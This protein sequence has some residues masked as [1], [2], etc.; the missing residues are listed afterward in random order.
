MLDLIAVISE[1]DSVTLL[2]LDCGTSWTSDQG[3]SKFL[4]DVLVDRDFFYWLYILVFG[5]LRRMSTQPYF[6]SL[7][8]G[9][10]SEIKSALTCTG[11]L[12]PDSPF[13]WGLLLLSE[14]CLLLKLS[15]SLLVARFTQTFRYSSLFWIF[16]ARQKGFKRRLGAFFIP[17][18]ICL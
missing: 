14:L 11:F 7:R 9:M 8:T 3:D 5:L 10:N 16:L 2:R 6:A 12:S 13:W 18:V 17:L 15:L 4:L 1:P